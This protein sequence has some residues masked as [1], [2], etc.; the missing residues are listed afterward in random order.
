MPVEFRLPASDGAHYAV[1]LVFA[2]LS[3]AGGSLPLPRLRDAFVLATSP[4][5]MQRLALPD[6]KTRAQAWAQRWKEDA[7]PAMF[8]D[9]LKAMGVRHLA[10][11]PGPEG[12][13]F[14]LQDGPRAPANED[15]GYDAWLALRVAS[16][17]APSA[18]LLPECA[19]WTKQAEEMVLT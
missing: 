5:L 12:R 6:D 1:S 19:A 17:L 9:C 13:I 15:V 2:L 3:E 18:V 14:Q 11:N 4:N 8:L 7:N 16:T 10:V